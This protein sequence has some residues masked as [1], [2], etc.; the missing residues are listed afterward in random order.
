MPHY[1]HSF[2]AAEEVRLTRRGLFPVI[3]IATVA[4][5]IVSCYA[6]LN[7]AYDK[8]A[9]HLARDI[10]IHLP[11][12]AGQISI[13]IQYHTGHM[14][15]GA[16]GIEFVGIIIGAC[17]TAFVLVM[18]HT[19]LW[20]P[21]HPIGLILGGALPL[22][23]LWSSVFIGWLIKY[24]ILK[25]GGLVSFQRWRFFFLGLILGEYFMVSF[26]M[27]V[28]YFTHISYSALPT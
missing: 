6:I 7:L 24:N 28:S 11:R 3:A 26:W 27:V 9:L 19:F 8:G 18:R 20:W 22:Y 23:H 21:L 15:M 25:F 12:G 17:T 5:Y 4:A 10:H 2:R 13:R 14:Q 16:G 1:L